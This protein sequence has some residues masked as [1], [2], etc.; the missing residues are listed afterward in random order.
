M[1]G[2][3]TRWRLNAMSFHAKSTICRSHKQIAGSR[4]NRHANVAH[5]QAQSAVVLPLSRHERH[6]MARLAH[7]IV[8]MV[9]YQLDHLN[10]LERVLIDF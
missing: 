7:Q 10:R 2:H 9:W 8:L 6:R 1:S 3:Q 5:Y 4:R